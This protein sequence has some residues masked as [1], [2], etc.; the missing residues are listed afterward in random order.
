MRVLQHNSGM[1][2]GF[3]SKAVESQQAEERQAPA[4]GEVSTEERE[5]RSR[6]DSLEMS[7]RGVL[8]ELQSVHSEL[9]RMTL[10][11]ALQFLDGEIRKLG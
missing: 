3:E 8:A 5:R 9:R 2:R 11:N 1:A 7:R 4:R 10:E 6:R